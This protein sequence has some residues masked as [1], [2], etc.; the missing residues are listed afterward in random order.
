M[1]G[2]ELPA[3]RVAVIGQ[4]APEPARPSRAQESYTT[5]D[6]FR[7]SIEW[8]V[9]FTYFCKK[10]YSELLRTDGFCHSAMEE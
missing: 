2:R 1:G 4:D 9:I 3:G 5:C 8:F 10:F 6:I 7:S